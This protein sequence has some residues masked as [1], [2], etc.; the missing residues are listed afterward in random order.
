MNNLPQVVLTRQQ[1][2]AMIDHAILKPETTLSMLKD[3]LM[4]AER[5]NVYSVCVR[6]VDVEQATTFLKELNSPVKVGTV[7]GFPHGSQSHNAKLFEIVEA[8]KSGAVEVDVVI[9]VGFLKDATQFDDAAQR[10]QVELKDLV[11]AAK[12]AGVEATKLILETALLS[13]EEV[14]FGAKL[15]SVAGFDFI[16]TSTGFAGEGATEH[17]L[18]LMKEASSTGVQLKASGGVS[19]LKLLEHFYNLGVTRFGT[20]KAELILNQVGK[21]ESER[22]SDE[23]PSAY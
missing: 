13:D 20:S 1:V 4:L 6:P 16:K 5:L 19:D 12:M 18:L 15:G 3:E 8:T 21:A 9:N 17:N 14:S 10:L 2:A 11:N 7:I 23:T 22:A